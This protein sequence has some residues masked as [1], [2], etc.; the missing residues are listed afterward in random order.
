[1]T[2]AN[3]KTA[4]RDIVRA[5]IRSDRAT[6]SLK[7]YHQS[8]GGLT[9]YAK[10]RVASVSAPMVGGA[11]ARTIRIHEL[12]HANHSPT[13]QPRKFHP[14]ANNAIEDARVHTVYWP[15][16]LPQ[17]AHRDCLTTAY[18]DAR[19][20]PALAG[21]IDADTW[22]VSLLV[23]LRSMAIADRL[24]STGR[25]SDRI[26]NRLAKSF[27]PNIVQELDDV[28]Q[29]CKSKRG[30]TKA[31]KAFSALMR[32][33]EEKQGAKK[34]EGSTGAMSVNPMQIVKL[35]MVE[36]CDATT[37]RTST[38]RSGARI[39]RSRL[40][41]AIATGS[42]A[43]LFIRQRYLPGGTYL[44]DASGSMQI[45]EERLNELCRKVPA[46]TVA[47]YSGT[48]YQRADGSYG[49]LV[50]YSQ[51]GQRAR[52]VANRYGGNSVDLFALQWLLKQ[53]GPRTFICDG[54]FCGGPDGQD[55]A[56]AKLLSMAVAN[57]DIV[58]Q[59][60]V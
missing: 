38:A 29:A 42:T 7:V 41:S 23:A 15:E 48:E 11:Q 24:H 26:A 36:P 37:K 34:G 17:R 53:P 25:R 40:A 39:N 57:G 35:P 18:R 27:P 58:W 12:L 32:S 56:A 33:D 60:S 50:I 30:R 1:M 4:I 8:I 20:L 51:G 44:F 52:E 22:N 47:Y 13:T 2:S 6:D 55:V 54:G 28:L 59:Q 31:L 16:S 46:A 45:S 49:D 9:T 43:G 10:K 21:M 3:K 14:L 19:K 5:G